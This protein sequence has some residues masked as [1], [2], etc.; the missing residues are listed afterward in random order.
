MRKSFVLAALA[1]IMFFATSG[2]AYAYVDP[3]A[4]GVFY[5]IIVLVFAVVAGYFAVFKGFIKRIFKKDRN[6]TEGDE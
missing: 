6:E 1:G 2:N 3:G 4:G 5:Q